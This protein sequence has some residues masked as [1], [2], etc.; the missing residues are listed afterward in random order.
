MSYYSQPAYCLWMASFSHHSVLVFKKN[1]YQITVTKI[2][3]IDVLKWTTLQICYQWPIQVSY[4]NL[5]WESF[6]ECRGKTTII[7]S[8][9]VIL[10]MTN[11]FA[12]DIMTLNVLL[13]IEHF[14]HSLSA[15]QGLSLATISIFL[16]AAFIKKF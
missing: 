10:T 15:H 11:E 9:W 12:R 2:T 7:T 3:L 4:Q 1:S 14:S 16:V 5:F 6:E 13:L 8:N